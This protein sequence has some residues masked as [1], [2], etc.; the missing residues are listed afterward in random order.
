MST[1]DH[2]KDKWTGG[3]FK[4]SRV[5]CRNKVQ[6]QMELVEVI[7]NNI[8]VGALVHKIVYNNR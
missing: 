5:I 2:D 6:H 4:L 7:T 8:I 1:G 3:A